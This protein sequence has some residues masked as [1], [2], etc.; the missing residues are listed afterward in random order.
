MDD[1]LRFAPGQQHIVCLTEETTDWRCRL[2]QEHRIVGISDCPLRPRRARENE[3]KVNA[4]L[5]AKADK[6]M[7]LPPD[8]M[9]TEAFTKMHKLI[10]ARMDADLAGAFAR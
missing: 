3:P 1:L 2:G 7:D 4:F 8:C 9:L 6:I 10:L 5:S